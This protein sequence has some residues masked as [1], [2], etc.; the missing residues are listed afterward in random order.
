MINT[1]ASLFSGIGG[2]ELAATWMGWQN[3]FHCEIQEFPR[4][5]LE[6]WYPNSISYE[7]ITKTDFTTWRGKID[8]LTGGFP[9]FVAGTPVLTKRGFIPI[10]EVKVGDEVLT[11]DKTYH[12]VEM[13]MRHHADRIVYMRAQGMYKDLKCTPNHPFFIRRKESYYEKGI[14]KIRY[15]AA[16]YVKASE[17]RKG[18]KVGYPVFESD[19][20]SYT[21]AFWKLVGTWLADVWIQDSLRSGKVNCRNNK[22]V[23]CCGK[24]N[25]ARLHHIIQAAG[26]K[27]TLSEDKS[28]YR[29]I[30]CDKW[31][32]DFLHDF[33]RYAYGKH[34]S[35]QCFMLERERKKALL[36]G[37]FADGYKKD[38]G[39][40]CVT[41]VSERLAQD[42]A[43]IARDVYLCP[44]SI[45]KK[46]C[47]RICLIEGREVNERPQ[48]CV[49]I[50]NSKRYGFYENGFIWCNVKSIRQ[51]YEE[52]EVF[53]LSVNEEHSYNVYGIAVHN[54]Q[55]FSCAGKRQGA[56]DDRYLWP[57]MLRAIRE[58]QPAWIVGENVA[59][60]LSMVQPGEETEMGRTDDLF[61]E[62]YIYRKEQ[63]F[64]LDEICEGL[65]CAGY[66]VQP[67]VVPACAVG[68]PHRRD[69]VW[70]VAHR[71]DAGAETV[72]C[73]RD[74]G[75]CPVIHASHADIDRCREREDKQVAVDGCKGASNDSTCGKN[76][77][78]SIPGSQRCGNGCDNRGMRQV[79]DDR[80]RNAE[81]S[82]PE[83]NERERRACKDGTTTTYT[84]CRGGREI[85]NEVQ[86]GQPNGQRAYGNGCER[87]VTHTTCEQSYRH[88]FEQQEALRKAESESGGEYSQSCY[89][90]PAD[91]WRD[92]PTQSP[93]RMR[94]DGISNNVV[95]YIKQEVYDAIK[96]HIRREDL[97]R[98]WKAF[99]KK[100]V[101]EKIGRLYE[102]PEP[103]L[104]LEILQRTSEEGRSPKEQ[105]GL[106]SFSER[107]SERVLR[108]LRKH[109]TFAS[110]PLGQKYKEQFSIQFE[111]SLP[112]LSHEIALATK[113]I[114]EECESTA[115]WWRQ[116][117]IKAYGNAMC[118]QVVYEIF[119]AIEE[120]YE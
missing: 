29:C 82:K 51:E 72:Q 25:I 119:R 106:S 112:E 24:K 33:G 69:R 83:R 78:S 99:Q 91:R 9:C 31:L 109:R 49:T 70:I 52:N 16:E 56:D 63:R 89:E 87:F 2:A 116:E 107:T 118:P 59:G 12:P 46:T 120:N 86:P 42:M 66:A 38:N 34:L 48:Y 75:V 108:Y 68:A 71:A 110:S 40:Q 64:T 102:I 57:E 23:I 3:L 50:S 104:L 37:W 17:I 101:R 90:L 58:I 1:H 4:R 84:Q 55:P 27:Y 92:F 79:R 94:Y 19:D 85:H 103:D 73:E 5:V 60:L 8:V 21:K 74:D 39:A 76:G 35:P 88:Q 96:E 11:T 81:E 7:D 6:Y 10:D 20:T 30:V 41:T 65:E 43:Q 93:V 13:T 32:C 80:E 67:F 28:T 114:V 77:T 15:L 54:C 117:S 105:G 115:N 100:E 14:S 22:V 26:Y 44:V 95:R 97:P 53:N 36:E 98:M 47:K 111:N 45:S 61:E 62:N 18:D 113:K